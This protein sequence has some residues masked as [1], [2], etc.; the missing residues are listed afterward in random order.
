MKQRA[1]GFLIMELVLAAALFSVFSAGI[2]VALLQGSSA[3]QA[4][5]QAETARFCAREG[6]EAARA[7]R[8]WSFA[9]LEN[10]TGSGL[11]LQAGQW[12]FFGEA[13][14]ECAAGYQRVI[15]V[16]SVERDGAGEIVA[17]DGTEDTD[18]KL[19][20]VT[21]TKGEYSAEFSAYLSR[22]E[23]VVPGP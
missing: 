11:R 6:I 12:E 10:T 20:T 2:V 14:E 5:Q 7:I 9:E 15:V 22:R 8:S 17:S 13:D 23:I 19:A 3:E 18:M 4:A 21:V 16:Q 1:K